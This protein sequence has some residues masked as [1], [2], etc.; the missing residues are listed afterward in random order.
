[1]PGP[2][3]IIKNKIVPSGRFT[4]RVKTG[5]FR[6][7]RLELDLRHETQVWLGLAER[8]VHRWLRKLSVGINSG[9]D[10]GAASG[11]YAL[12]FLTQT[13]AST[14]LAFEPHGESRELFIR[15]ITLNGLQKD[16]RWKLL[17]QFVGTSDEAPYCTL[18]S[19]SH[20]V[21]GPCLIKIDVDGGEGAILRGADVLLDRPDVRWI[22]ETHSQALEMDCLHILNTAGYK[23]QVVPN[24][25]WRGV[26][27]EQRP[28]PLNRWL[29]AYRDG[30]V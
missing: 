14:V 12:Y 28:I 26:I 25:W 10:I 19:I 6:G 3:S 13:S 22:I 5:A 17:E 8:E 18:N 24:A 20:H 23:T 27:P 15:N 9:I 1:M 7:L 16:P 21:Q 4:R 29:I 11:E 2:L 30:T